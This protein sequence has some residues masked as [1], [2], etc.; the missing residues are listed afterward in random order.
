MI[1]VIN[2]HFYEDDFVED[3]GYVFL[4]RITPLS[5]RRECRARGMSHC[6]IGP[7]FAGALTES[8]RLIRLK[9]WTAYTIYYEWGSDNFRKVW[10]RP[11]FLSCFHFS[12]E[13]D[14]NHFLVLWRLGHNG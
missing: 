9:P 13:A 8:L 4:S 2:P 10:P 11:D 5:A 14:M 6:Y 1:S 3:S 12:S 7:S